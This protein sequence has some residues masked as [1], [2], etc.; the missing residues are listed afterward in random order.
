MIKRTFLVNNFK[1]IK[2]EALEL[3]HLSSMN[4]SIGG[5]IT[6]IGP[7]NSGKSNL[8]QA[9]V[10]FSKENFTQEMVREEEGILQTEKFLLAISLNADNQ[11]F[12]LIKNQKNV[13]FNDKEIRDP[14]SSS[15]IPFTSF[16]TFASQYGYGEDDRLRIAFLLNNLINYFDLQDVILQHEKKSRL[17]SIIQNVKRR[18]LQSNYHFNDTFIELAK[19]LSQAN[20]EKYLSKE[21]IETH[22]RAITLFNNALQNPNNYRLADNQFQTM[23]LAKPN[24]NDINNLIAKIT[25]R[26]KD[27]FLGGDGLKT[28]ISINP[29]IM[30]YDDKLS[31]S[32]TDLVL[33][34]NNANNQNRF[35]NLLFKLVSDYSLNDL[36]K[37]YENFN[38]T[39]ASSIA[40]LKNLQRKLNQK[41][42]KISHDFSNIYHVNQQKYRFELDLESEKVF[43]Q[44]FEGNQSISL[45]RQSTG[46]KWFFNFYFNMYSGNG[47]QAGDLVVMD[48]PA[49]NLHV[50]GQIELLKFIREFGKNNNILIIISTHSPSLIDIDYLDEIRIIDKDEIGTHITNKF[51]AIKDANKK[52]RTSDITAP[53]RSSLTIT[54]NYLVEFKQKIVFVE[55]ITDYGYLIAMRN[56][57]SESNPEFQSLKFIPF[58]GVTDEKKN[59]KTNVSDLF[60]SIAYHPIVLVD[61]DAAGQDFVSKNKQSNLELLTL[62]DIDESFKE[63]EDLFDVEDKKLLNI[64]NKKNPN[65][66]KL[67]NNPNLMTNVSKKTLENFKLLFKSLLK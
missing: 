26:L 7:N 5:V 25:E 20:L 32:N 60:N 19:F 46:F 54:P 42:E 48:E 10:S 65:A 44:I 29:N 56:K 67:K 14:N 1:S 8:L 4:E 63:I 34:P 47:L 43:F 13:L 24:Q 58:D 36:I 27:S 18:I 59:P 45:D 49:T 9:L 52:E 30:P 39:G 23:I 15:I 21:F 12:K 61:S 41:L 3:N 64:E 17:Y 38:N 55:G 2:D 53:I 28:P 35:Y 22:A 57:L 33:Y 51:N 6:L 16:Q 50:S 37:A 62:K 40:G 31:F 11:S 66:L